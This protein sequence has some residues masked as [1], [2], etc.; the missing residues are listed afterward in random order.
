[1]CCSCLTLLCRLSCG[2]VLTCVVPTPHCSVDRFADTD[3]I[4]VVP[5]WPPTAQHSVVC[6]NWPTRLTFM[7]HCLVN[8]YTETVVTCVANESTSHLQH[9]I[10]STVLTSHLF[11]DGFDLCCSDFTLLCQVSCGMALSCVAHLQP[12][13]VA[14]VSRKLITQ[15]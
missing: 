5:D 15:S 2:T 1:M 12:F 7:A 9:K 10:P 6:F 3:L 13:Q 14:S 8:R 4:C 11:L